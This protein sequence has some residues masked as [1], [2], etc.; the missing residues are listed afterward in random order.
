MLH[1]AR[2][3]AKSQGFEN[4]RTKKKTRHKQPKKPQPAKHHQ[5]NKQSRKDEQTTVLA[6]EKEEFLGSAGKF[7]I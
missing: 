6:M 4:W 3:P 1:Q 5:T 2:L 7:L